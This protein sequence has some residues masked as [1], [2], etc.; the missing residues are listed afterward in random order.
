MRCIVTGG[1]G[2][3]GSYLTEQLVAMGHSVAVIDDMFRGKKK[4]LEGCKGM[5][6]YFLV[7]GDA[8]ERSNYEK[9]ADKLGGVDCVYHLAA[10]N[11]TRWFHERPDFVIQVNLNTLRVALDFSITRGARFVFTSSPEA[12][13]EQP[14]M[15]LTNDSDS[16][17]TSASL[18]GRHSYGAS[19]YLGE[20]MVQHAVSNSS[21]DGRIVRPFNAYGPRLPG[22]AY[23]QVTGIFLEQCRK[24]EPI[25]VHGDGMQTRSFTWVEEVV[26]GIRIAGELEEGLDGSQL[27][28][29]AFNLGSTEEVN[30][31]ELANLCLEISGSNSEIHFQET[32]HPGDSRRRTPDISQTENALGWTPSQSLEDGLRSCWRWLQ[33]EE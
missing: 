4:N 17:F 20:I 25:T 15:P 16:L 18:H 2:F 19:K 24:E 10:I 29:A 12:F 7:L 1:A 6:G 5:D 21:L 30:V 3:L 8:A 13:G 31:A 27:A 32:G 11:G 23:G 33:A 14:E 26:E 9:A 22:D 28:G